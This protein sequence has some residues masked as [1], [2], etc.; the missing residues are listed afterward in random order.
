MTARRGAAGFERWTVSID[1]RMTS[2][3]R[4]ATDAVSSINNTRTA[5]ADIRG[6]NGAI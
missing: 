1:G 2:V 5:L 3:R 6:G 4:P